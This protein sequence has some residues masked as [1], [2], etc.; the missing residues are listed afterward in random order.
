MTRTLRLELEIGGR[1]RRF[2]SHRVVREDHSLP[3]RHY[4]GRYPEFVRDA[5]RNLAIEIA[6]ESHGVAPVAEV[7][8][9]ERLCHCLSK[10]SRFQ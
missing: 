4:I 7:T 1:R 5:G 3:L 6:D 2:K 8:L 10:R 9:P